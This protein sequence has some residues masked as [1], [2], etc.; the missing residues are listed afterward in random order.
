MFT[1]GAV[2]RRESEGIKAFAW[3]DKECM[4]SSEPVNPRT[5]STAAF[6]ICN[7]KLNDVSEKSVN[8]L[9]VEKLKTSLPVVMVKIG[10]SRVLRVPSPLFASFT[11]SFVW[12]LCFTVFLGYLFIDMDEIW[13]DN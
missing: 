9:T 3:L 6:V 11:A 10:S 8:K 5:M 2:K 13:K 4:P 1:L 7:G 12:G